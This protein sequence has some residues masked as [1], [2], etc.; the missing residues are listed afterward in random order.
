MRERSALTWIWIALGVQFAGYV[1]D[2]VWH[3]LIAPGVEPA[4]VG[5]MIHHLATVHVP[6]YIGAACVVVATVAA[7][8]R[9]PRR[10]IALPVAS[11]GAVV[12]AG[13]EGWHAASHLRLDTHHAPVAGVLSFVGFLVVVVAMSLSSWAERRRAA[14]A[15]SDDRRVA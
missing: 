4:T 13:A 11:V 7:L 8:A 12:S 6:L 5:A 2:A 1:F 14:A 10:G 3:G 15:T 9:T